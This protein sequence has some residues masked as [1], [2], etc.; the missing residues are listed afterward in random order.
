[1]QRDQNTQGFNATSPKRTTLAVCLAV[2]LALVTSGVARGQTEAVTVTSSTNGDIVVVTLQPAEGGGYT[3]DGEP[4]AGGL[5]TLEN[6]SAYLVTLATDGTWTAAYQQVS[7]PVP[8]NAMESVTLTRLEDGSFALPDGEPVTLATRYTTASGRTYGVEIGEDGLPRPVYVPLRVTVPLG[9]RGSVELT[10]GEDLTWAIGDRAV[11]SGDMHEGRENALT[12]EANLYRLTL[13]EGRWTATYEAAEVPIAGTDLVARPREDGRGYQVGE[14]TLSASGRGDLTLAAP[15][16]MDMYHVWATEDGLAGARFDKRIE[17]AVYTANVVGTAG[18]PSLSADNRATAANELRTQVK[19]AGSDFELGELLDGGRA[20]EEPERTLLEQVRTELGKLRAQVQGLVD[21]RNNDGIDQLTLSSQLVRKWNEADRQVDRLFGAADENDD[22]E[23]DNRLE[24]VLSATRVLGAFDGL[25]EA[26]ETEDA[27]VEATAASEGG[28]Y[29]FAGLGEAAA[30]RAFSAREWSA[31][32]VF[33]ALGETRYG[34]VVRKE[35]AT[36]PAASA[37]TQNVQAF[38]WATTGSPW[39]ASDVEVSGNAYYSG[40]TLAADKEGA[41]YSGEIA[42]QVRFTR[43]RVSGVVSNLMTEDGERFDH[44]LGGDVVNIALPSATMNTR[45]QW[46]GR[47]EA[48][49]SYERRA[50]GSRDIMLG[51]AAFQGRLLGTGSDAG[52]QAV[53]TWQLADGNREDV[54]IAGGFGAVRGP[55]RADPTQPLLDDVTTTGAT[56]TRLARTGDVITPEQ[57]QV[58]AA[59]W[60]DLVDTTD[61]IGGGADGLTE[62]RAFFRSLASPMVLTDAEVDLIVATSNQQDLDG[63]TSFAGR[64]A[65]FVGWVWNDAPM[66]R[67]FDA[68]VKPTDRTART[69]FIEDSTTLR[70]WPLVAGGTYG[71]HPTSRDPMPD[72]RRGDAIVHD[73]FKLNLDIG[74]LFGEGYAVPETTDQL[75]NQATDLFVPSGYTHVERARKELTRLQRVLRSVIALDSADASAADRKFTND[76]RQSLFTQIQEQ[77]TGEIFGG[78]VAEL[79]I[80]GSREEDDALGAHDLWTAHVD[81]PVNGAG[82]PQDAQLL[83]DIDAAIAA[84][85]SQRALESAFRTGGVFAGKNDDRTFSSSNYGEPQVTSVTI[86]ADNF[87][88]VVGTVV[89]TYLDD[90]SLDPFTEDD[91]KETY[92]GSRRVTVASPE[93]TLPISHIWTKAKARAL[94]VTDSTDFT[95]FGMWSGQSSDFA[96]DSGEGALEGRRGYASFYNAAVDPEPFAYSP[97]DQVA[98]RGVDDPATPAGVEA[99]YRGRSVAVMSEDFMTA[100]ALARVSWSEVWSADTDPKIGELKLTI[101][102]IES[103]GKWGGLRFGLRDYRSET[104]GDF[105]EPRPG[106]FDVRALVFRANIRVDSDQDNAVVFANDGVGQENVEVVVESLTGQ[107]QWLTPADLDI[108]LLDDAGAPTGRLLYDN[109]D[110]AFSVNDDPAEITSTAI[111]T[112]TYYAEVGNPFRAFNWPGSAVREAFD[113]FYSQGAGA[114]KMN[115][116]EGIVDLSADVDGKFVGSTVDG[117]LGA[118]GTWALT[119]TNKFIFLAEEYKSHIVGTFGVELVPDP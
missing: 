7:L 61:S 69:W 89:S 57:A 17:G 56:V 107:P 42:L 38:A 110:D 46:T 41:L 15:G 23:P 91:V 50:G 113:H 78:T 116:A 8:L 93:F 63:I 119:G 11:A 87:D 10:R 35:R 77:L 3:R 51:G 105:E 9:T 5:V 64:E 24:R 16:G 6:G 73:Y 39:Q 54:L 92:H 44:G 12:G 88:T 115:V 118:I 59:P 83:G 22:S 29:A 31:E 52:G 85:S 98:Y 117:P 74:T 103:R 66:V 32:A 100:D 94:L 28:V 60:Q 45:G 86:S 102:N 65:D 62:A 20:T 4:F 75:T 18:A 2:L 95:R 76:R 43:Q 99:T 104:S 101:S 30:V 47:G 14:A 81:Y 27:F 19:L 112:K 90:R 70:I 71:N 96:M 37:A 58:D 21:L 13:A 68:T 82:Q 55:D 97:L 48:R 49:L 36:A 53:G 79:G 34:A 111:E 33:G 72:P 114:G 108:R 40:S 25:L 84:L 26:L 67:A 1:M 80:F 106:T 109:T